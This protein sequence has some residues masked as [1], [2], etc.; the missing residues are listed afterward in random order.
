MSATGR[1][2]KPPAKPPAKAL[3]HTPGPSRSANLLAAEARRQAG[4]T[5]MEAA[6]RCAARTPRPRCSSADARKRSGARRRGTQCKAPA[7]GWATAGVKCVEAPTLRVGASPAFARRCTS[8][9]SL[10]TLAELRALTRAPPRVPQGAPEAWPSELCASQGD[11][12]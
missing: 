11:G 5:A 4:E 3:A 1:G 2:E 8:D 7:V 6:K 10:S 9:A 12:G